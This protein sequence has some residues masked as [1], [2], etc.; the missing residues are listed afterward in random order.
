MT[1][2]ALFTA[3]AALL[4]VLPL[5]QAQAA[6]PDKNLEVQNCTINPINI[7]I[8]A[9]CSAG[10]ATINGHQSGMFKLDL[11]KKHNIHITDAS[12]RKVDHIFGPFF[13]PAGSYWLYW[14]GTNLTHQ[15]EKCK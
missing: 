12:G 10:R 11:L 8:D 6:M 4:A 5:Q 3:G 15:K 1:K 14:T 9:N 7:C 13:N 2:F